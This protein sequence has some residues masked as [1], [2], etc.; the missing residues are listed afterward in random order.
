MR[1]FA[2]VKSVDGQ[3]V[4]VV[5]LVS[6]ACVTCNS[7]ECARQ[8][9]T[10]YVI[11]RR[12]LPLHENSIIRI[13]FPRVLNGIFGLIALLFPIVS[14]AAGFFF[15]PALLEHFEYKVT[16]SAVACVIGVFFVVSSLIVFLMS[17]TDIHFTK[18]E[19][20]QIM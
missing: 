1:D 20:I 9:K 7:I 3:N 11:N 19:V 6:D 2:I 4:E 8:G 12:K 18:P 13:G 15:A 17:R 10:F 5:S 14:A 16:Q